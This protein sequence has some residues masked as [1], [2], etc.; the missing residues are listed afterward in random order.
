MFAMI[1]DCRGANASG[2]VAYRCL[3]A[4]KKS[5]VGRKQRRKEQGEARL[6][7]EVSNE[8]VALEWNT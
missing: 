1:A 3:A 4:K 8:R 7:V 6:H 2:S 5:L